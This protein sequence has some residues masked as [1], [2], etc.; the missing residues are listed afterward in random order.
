MSG[1][2][3]QSTTV[4]R[5]LSGITY[6]LGAFSK[7]DFFSHLEAFIHEIYGP[8]LFSF[9]AAGRSPKLKLEFSNH[10]DCPPSA[11]NPP[12]SIALPGDR[13]S[14]SVQRA[15]FTVGGVA[16]RVDTLKPI[17]AGGRRLGWLVFHEPAE[18]ILD[19]E[20]A[21][22]IES[23][24]F[25]HISFAYFRLDGQE[26]VQD[27]LDLAEAKLS[28]INA[29]GELIS[30]LDLDVLLTKLLELSLFIASAQVGS[31][32]LLGDQEIESRVE[33]GLPLEVTSRLA[34]RG[35]PPI[36]EQVLRTGKPSLIHAFSRPEFDG[37][38]D[39]SVDSF[40]CIP[41]LT[42]QKTLGAINLINIG[43][44]VNFSA[45]SILTISGLAATAI[46]NAILHRE[47]LERERITANLQIARSIQDRMYPKEC[48][49]L[50]GYQMAW[51]NQ[52]CD[53]TGGDYF[54]FIPLDEHTLS[55][56]IGDVTGHGIGAALLMAAGRANLRALLSAKQGLR[57]VMPA[58][59]A[60]L[61]AD[62]DSEKFMTLFVGMIDHR[63]HRLTYLN[64]GHDHPLLYRSGSGSVEDLPA[65]GLPLGI[66]GLEA[67]PVEPQC[68]RIE[69]GDALLLSTD[70]VWEEVNTS[71]ERFG[72][73]RLLEVF[74]RS[75]G[76]S[77]AEIVEAVKAE[78]SRFT[79]GAERKDDF[80]LV[81]IK[82]Q[83]CGG[84]RGTVVAHGP[85]G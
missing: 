6:L 77:A 71:Q 15:A 11:D 83:E 69:P 10:P 45:E 33:W 76:G 32:V 50:P 24:T 64:A 73:K 30:S 85:G 62:M 81:V 66:L 9:L 56:V 49:S 42:K 20:E 41:L 23:L 43:D 29:M 48:P 19:Q 21:P 35:G 75:A 52:S 34:L 17:S 1:W 74:R 59:D 37:V 53:E 51:A 16:L 26:K 67:P 38:P 39:L 72:K 28:A 36:L 54:D 55:V 2:E 27:Q 79:R 70:G 5:V 61:A 65:T 60:L 82:R 63:S 8:V 84:E 4:E 58:M 80:T 25:D 18:V 47:H 31:V 40:F 14:W 46:E 68:R 44:E 22:A 3:M 12:V 78:F 7:Y 57:E 13:A